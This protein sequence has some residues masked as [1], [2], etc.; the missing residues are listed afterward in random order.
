MRAI[1]L[2]TAILLVN[3]TTLANGQGLP[4]QP[5]N[6]VLFVADGLR[7][8]MVD[9][10]TAPTMAAL[11]RDGVTLRN[12]HALF[13][14]FT[15]ANASAMATGYMPTQFESLYQSVVTQRPNSRHEL[16]D[17]GPNFILRYESLGRSS[18]KTSGL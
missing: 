4:Q 9:E 18:A 10:S 16:P 13:P 5:H 17:D 2:G 1:I 3:L 11:A 12:G 8:R 7:F 15:T 6:V 14:T